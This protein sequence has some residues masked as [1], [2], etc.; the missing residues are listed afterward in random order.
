MLKVITSDAAE[1]LFFVGAKEPSSRRAVG[2]LEAIKDSCSE[3]A[4]CSENLNILH[5]SSS[6]VKDGTNMNSGE[7]GGLWTLLEELRQQNVSERHLIPLLKVWCSVHRSQ[8]AWK[9]VTETVSELKILIQELKGFSTYFHT[10]GVRTRELKQ[11]GDEHKLTVKRFPEYFQIR[12]TEFLYEMIDSFLSSWHATALYFEKHST[13]KEARG[14]KKLMTDK[15]K[16]QLLCFVCDVLAV[17]KRYQKIIQDDSITILGV[18]KKTISVKAQLHSLLEKNLEGGWLEALQSSLG[19]DGLTLKGV[20]LHE[21]RERRVNHQFVTVTRDHEAIKNEI[22]LSLQEFLTQRFDLDKNVVEVLKPFAGLKSETDM[23]KVHSTICSDLDLTELT[24]E[25]NDLINS[26]ELHELQQLKLPEIVQR[27]FRN[28][29]L[30]PNL[31]TA[32]SRIWAAKPHSYDVERVISACNL[33]K[34]F[35]RNRVAV[36]TQ[37]LYLY[38]HFNMCALEDW[39]PRPCIIKWLSKRAHRKRSTEKAR[40]QRWFKGTFKEA[41]CSDEPDEEEEACKEGKNLKK[42]KTVRKMF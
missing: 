9:S 20:A 8:L 15:A 7:R 35:S 30:F 39:D 26:D 32:F 29:E 22:I 42:T 24:M 41:D 21:A 34:T 18:E 14:F 1:E 3:V 37:N 38:I 17:F 12:F 27:L 25:F 10:S 2:A 6:I 16:L 36:D 4:V 28:H 33:L 40:S 31:I 11:I 19:E 5:E 23:K 13:Y